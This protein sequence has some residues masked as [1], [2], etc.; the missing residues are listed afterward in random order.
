[1]TDDVSRALE[2]GLVNCSNCGYWFTSEAQLIKHKK[3]YKVM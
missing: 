2:Q 3:R 1:M